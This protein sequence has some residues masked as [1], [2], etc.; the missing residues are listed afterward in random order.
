MNSHRVSFDL[1][2]VWRAGWTLVGVGALVALLTFLLRAGGGMIFLVVI[3]LFLAVAMEPAVSRLAA[4][5]PRL[6]ATAIVMV[7]LTLAIIG[8]TYAFGS[9]L[10]GQLSALITAVPGAVAALPQWI[11]EQFGI[12]IDANELQSSLQL[13]PEKAAQYAAQVAGG[14]FGV[15]GTVLS[16]A[17]SMFVMAMFTFYLSAD[18]PRLRNW[19]ITL[20]PPHRQAFVLTAWQ[21]FLAKVGGYVGARFTLAVI[22]ATIHSLF[23]LAIGMPY[24][25]ALGLWTG[26]VAQ[27][28]PNVGTYIAIMLPTLVGLASPEPADGVLVLIFAIAYQQVENLTIEPR[29][30]GRAVDVHPALSFGSALLGAQLFG[31]PGAVL[32]VPVAAT[33]MALFDIYSTRYELS[34]DAEHAASAAVEGELSRTDS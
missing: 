31:L 2:S 29:I 11:N 32:G 22:S 12:A 8:F 17:F 13:T 30:S 27:F 28:V 1:R 20:V 14:A 26:L 10:I 6:A 18:M 19:V 33:L 21:L 24:W 15:L 9:L 4:R 34:A 5:I 23:M 16:A 25:L 7:L 3:S